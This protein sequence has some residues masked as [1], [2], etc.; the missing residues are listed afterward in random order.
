MTA[1]PTPK[2]GGITIFFH[3]IDRKRCKRDYLYVLDHFLY[4][5]ERPGKTVR[6]VATTPPQKILTLIIRCNKT[7]VMHYCH[8]P[9]S[10]LS[11]VHPSLHVQLYLPIPSAHVPLFIHGLLE[12]SSMSERWMSSTDCDFAF[13]RQRQY[14]ITMV[15]LLTAKGNIW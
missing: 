3:Q 1:Y 4:R 9:I 12:H 15:L 14:M 8:L 13:T 7:L 5:L 2:E 6:G 10:Q 11:P